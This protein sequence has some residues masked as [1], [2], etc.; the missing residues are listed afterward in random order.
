[1]TLPCFFFGDLFTSSGRD[2]RQG[3]TSNSVIRGLLEIISK[4][5]SRSLEIPPSLRRKELIAK[6]HTNNCSMLYVWDP[7]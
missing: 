1:M 6:E 4:G 2:N 3:A 7:P 5:T